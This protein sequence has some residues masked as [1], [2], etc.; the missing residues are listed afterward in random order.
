VSLTESS[1]FATVLK[2]LRMAGGLS[3]EALAE[4]AAISTQAISAL[5]TGLRKAP[6]PKTVA[7]LADALGLDNARRSQ[8]A[9]AATLARA[10][11]ATAS[12]QRDGNLPQPLGPVIGRSREVAELEAALATSRLVTV[13]GP[14]G[15]GKTTVA[16][17]AARRIGSRFADGTYFCDLSA[18]SDGALIA[19]TIAAARGVRLRSD[20]EPADALA[21]ALRPSEMLLVLDNCEHVV[22]HAS[23]TASV[24]LKVCPKLAILATS[25]RPLAITAEMTFRPPPLATPVLDDDDY[26][27]ATDAR[28]FSA[29]ALFEERARAVQPDFVLTDDTAPIVA[30]ICSRLDGIA[31]AIELAAAQMRA[32]TAWELAQ[33]LDQRFR[34]LRDG[35]YADAPRQRTLAAAFDWSYALLDQRQ[36][37]FFRSL[38]IFA[39]GFTLDAALEICC[40]PDADELTALELLAALV[41]ASLLVLDSGATTTR[42]RLLE[43]TRAYAL[44]KLVEQR[45]QQTLAARHLEYHRA[46]APEIAL[47]SHLEDVRTALLWALNGGDIAAGAELAA[48]IGVQWE[49]AGIAAE[50]ASRLTAFIAAVDQARLD[51]VARL[52]AALSFLQGNALRFDES[53]AA[54]R[55]AVAFARKVDDDAVLFN[56]LRSLSVFASWTSEFDESRKALD[57]ATQIAGPDPAPLRR[58]HLLAA[59]GHLERMS[60]DYDGAIIAFEEAQRLARSLGDEYREVSATVHLSEVEHERGNTQQAAALMRA[61]AE[62]RLNPIDA[63]PVLAN[64]TGYLAALGDVPGARTAAADFFALP[65]PFTR[66]TFATAVLEHVALADASSGEHTRAARLLG[67]CDAWY[68][69]TGQ[70]RQFTERHARGQLTTLLD[71]HIE[72]KRRESLETEGAEYTPERAVRTALD[73]DRYSGPGPAATPTGGK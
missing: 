20:A 69:T 45:E 11:R 41:D 10:A 48:T 5:E 47:A 56:A 16:L 54:A 43:T 61:L 26:L 4:R 17:E 24:L 63:E 6:Y 37:R 73:N 33:R 59:R 39:G 42:Y 21:S 25:R 36:Q 13:L 55:K 34:L 32:M 18:V 14:G 52:W 62:R 31:L 66:S 30:E 7:L 2:R 72:T 60:G 1:D 71:R 19:G 9:D 50:G 28:T 3:Q 38:G 8:L 46:H 22:E 15:I 44:G 12:E 29:I 58:L 70:Q 64:L 57:E 35:R 68:R 40:E 53:L 23:R 27:S 51:L 49:M 65:L 67:Y